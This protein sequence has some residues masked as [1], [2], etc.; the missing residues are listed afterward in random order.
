LSGVLRHVSLALLILAACSEERD[1]PREDPPDRTETKAP[2]PERETP[3]ETPPEP[4]NPAEPN[5]VRGARSSMSTRYE[6]TIVSDDE[7]AANRAIEEALDEIDRLA[8]VLS[9]WRED[10]EVSA[11]NRQAGIAPVEV[12]PDTLTNVRE[13]LRMAEWTR[14]GYDISW[15]ALRGLYT[16]Q[17]GERNVPDLDVVREKLAFVGYRDIVLD[18]EA[19]TVF[20]RRRGMAIGLGGI[21]KGY[22]ADR[23][24]A[25]VT[26]HGFENFMVFAGGQV[27]VHGRK[28][29][30]G[31]R[32]GVQHPRRQEEYIGFVEVTNASVATSGD[33][34]HSFIDDEGRRWHH[35]IDL[36]TGLPSTRTASV[37]LVAPNGILADGLDTGCFVMGPDACLEMLRGLPDRIEAIIIDPDMK[38]SFSDGIRDHFQWHVQVDAEGRLP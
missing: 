3:E 35:I 21:A 33:Y 5:L 31:W 16:F 7:A 10:S 2:P 15:A 32:V 29:N 36:S 28:G 30:R 20:L 14:G 26:R 19:H 37:T 9:E 1:Q 8:V 27:L 4:S 6:V 38:V 17:P 22:A 18:E 13:G 23:A 12:G 25:I 11:V 24:A 34:E